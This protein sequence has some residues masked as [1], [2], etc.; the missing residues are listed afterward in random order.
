[1]PTIGLVTVCELARMIVRDNVSS[2]KLNEYFICSRP[3]D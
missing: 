1:M 3:V 2:E